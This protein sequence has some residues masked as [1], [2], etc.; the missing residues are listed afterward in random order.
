MKMTIKVSFARLFKVLPNLRTLV[1]ANE[2][3][4]GGS[5][6]APPSLSAAAAEARLIAIELRVLAFVGIHGFDFDIRR[7]PAADGASQGDIDLTLAEESTSD[8]EDWVSQWPLRSY[9]YV[10]E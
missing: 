2:K 3:K 9:A 6:F 7:V 1:I 10:L 4:P 8:P 5:F